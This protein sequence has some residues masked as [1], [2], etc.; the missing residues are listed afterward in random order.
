MRRLAPVLIRPSRNRHP[1]RVALVAETAF[2][3]V[4]DELADGLRLFTTAFLG[5][6]VFFGTLIA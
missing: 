5:G 6:L 4:S 2:E 1:V 3:P